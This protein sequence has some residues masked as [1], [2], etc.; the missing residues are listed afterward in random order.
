MNTSDAE[1]VLLGVFGVGV[2]SIFLDELSCGGT[3]KRPIECTCP[4]TPGCSRGHQEDAGV[5][6]EGCSVT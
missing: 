5:R 4:L 3:E 6:C 2:G 1:A